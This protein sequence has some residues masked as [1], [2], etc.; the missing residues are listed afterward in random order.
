MQP[1]LEFFDAGGCR[2]N[3]DAL[4][5]TNLDQHF[6]TIG[7]PEELLFD[8][9]HAHNGKCEGDPNDTADYELVA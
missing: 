9:A 3:A 8:G 1:A 6:G 2:L 4:R 7:G 5:P